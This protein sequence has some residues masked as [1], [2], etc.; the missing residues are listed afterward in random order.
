MVLQ[1]YSVARELQLHAGH[2]PPNT[3]FPVGHKTQDQFVGDQSAHQPLRILEIMLTPTWS[4][5]RKRLRQVQTHVGLQFQHT[6]RQYR[7][8]DSITASS[9]PC[10]RNHIN[11]RCNSLGMV[12]NRRRPGFS[13]GVLASTISLRVFP[14]LRQ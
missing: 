7:A 1:S 3:L 10:S 13:S 5:V 11:R 14:A 8:V 12:M 2:A 9:T 6:D 4:T